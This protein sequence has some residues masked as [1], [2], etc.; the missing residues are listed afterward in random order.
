MHS[1]SIVCIYIVLG[2]ELRLGFKRSKKIKYGRWSYILLIKIPEVE[3]TKSRLSLYRKLSIIVQF[4]S[5]N[6]VG[7]VI[8]GKKL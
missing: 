8:C 5:E 3:G 1:A 4:L 7:S 6:L 2:V